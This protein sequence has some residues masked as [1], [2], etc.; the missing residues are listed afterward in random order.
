MTTAIAPRRPRRTV[1]AGAMLTGTVLAAVMP[2]AASAAVLR[3][4]LT[5]GSIAPAASS[6]TIKLT[7]IASG[8]SSPR[9]HHQRS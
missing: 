1:L 4:Q 9:A 3:T 2:T 5:D 8:L 6:S 7:P